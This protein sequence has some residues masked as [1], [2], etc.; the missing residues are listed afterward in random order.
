MIAKITKTYQYEMKDGEDT[1]EFVHGSREAIMAYAKKQLEPDTE[2]RNTVEFDDRG[3]RDIINLE[4]GEKEGVDPGEDKITFV[5]WVTE[6]ST[7]PDYPDEAD[8]Y[9]E[10]ALEVKFVKKVVEEIEPE[11]V[12]AV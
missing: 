5:S 10:Y 11:E 4:T 9:W 2:E 7:D 6:P 3:E 1:E 12:T 8:H